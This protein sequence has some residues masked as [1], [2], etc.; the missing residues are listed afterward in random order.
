MH[1]AVSTQISVNNLRW[2][3]DG[4]TTLHQHHHPFQCAFCQGRSLPL[5]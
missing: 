1:L 2:T 4:S 3:I 5:M